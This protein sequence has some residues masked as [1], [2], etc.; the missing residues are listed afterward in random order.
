MSKAVEYGSAYA[1]TCTFLRNIENST[2]IT[3]FKYAHDGT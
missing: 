2:G 1:K 3:S